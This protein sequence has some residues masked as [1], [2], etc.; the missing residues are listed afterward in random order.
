MGDRRASVRRAFDFNGQIL[1]EV[2]TLWMKGP[3]SFTG[4]DVV[5]ISAHGNPMILASIIEALV[6]V[7]ARPA[8]P[9]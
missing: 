6:K 8:R 1:D 4:E 5:E 9:G 2:L 7:G 3:K